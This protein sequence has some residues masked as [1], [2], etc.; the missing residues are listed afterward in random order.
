[1]TPTPLHRAGGNLPADVT[2]F[3]GRRREITEVKR[4]L[5]TARL[6]TLTGMGG[7][8]KTRLALRTAADLRRGF[9]HGVWVVE[10]AGLQ[11]GGL[12][13]E[14]VCSALRIHDRAAA[15][16]MGML[17]DFLAARQLL[18]ILDN[19]EHVI[20]ECA[21]LLDELLRSCPELRVLTT[22]R[23][24][25]GIAGEHTLVVPPLS[26]PESDQDLSPERLRMY[27]AVNL[28]VER[29]VA[30]RPGFAIDA[31]NKDAIARICRR[32]DGIPL[33]LELAAGRLRALSPQQLLERLDDR[34]RLLT[35]GS[36]TALPRQQTLRALIDWSYELCSSD[37]QV[38]WAR[39]STFAD[40]FDVDAAEEVCATEGLPVERVLD[41]VAGLVDK[42]VL[43]ADE[44]GGRVRYLLLETL[45]EYGLDRLEA[46]G[47][48]VSMRRR[49]LAWCHRF[50]IEAESEWAGPNQVEWFAR[51]Q[52]EHGNLR[53]ALNFCLDEPGESDRG[54]EMAS[55][56]R[57]Y[58]LTSGRLG[59]GRLWLDR[60]LATGSASNDARAKGMYVAGYLAIMLND[61]AAAEDRLAD[62]R[63]LAYEAGNASSCAYIDQISGLS[64]LF[65]GDS[66]SASAL[67]GSALA[68]HTLLGDQ[69]AIVYD[70]VGLAMASG[71]LG[72]GQRA[73]ELF[74]RC[75]AATES[76]GEHWLRALTLWALGI[77]AC[78]Q[79]DFR[80]A[81]DAQRKS[82]R[83]RLP[84]NDRW[85][86]GLNLDALAW[87]VAAEGD[88]DRAARLFGAAEAIP[89]TVG[90][91]LATLG[92][93]S[94]L[95]SAYLTAVRG[96][97]GDAAFE[98]AFQQ[99][100]A[101]SF[102]EAVAFALGEVVSPTRD[103]PAD[104]SAQRDDALT[105]RE[106]EIAELIARGLSNKEIASTLV[107]AQRTAE[108]H[109]GHILTKLGFTSRVQVA[110]W[111]AGN[112]V[113]PGERA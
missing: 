78:R 89:Q 29:A 49:Q 33:A 59:E 8:G 98:Q 24:S 100:L 88:N 41:T 40:G 62:A 57:Y 47:E 64:A 108:A 107:I 4:L 55:A 76:R 16:S 7:V 46:T 26:L 51:L 21:R 75:V 92:Q 52:L 72:D 30:L 60:L 86:I 95:H 5:P 11:D 32:L 73:T 36:R 67:F 48:I 63:S 54:L 25:L 3:I 56:L 69:T 85:D 12:V 18:L 35:G 22:S 20:E 66:A 42:S 113:A 71:L 90:T 28:L 93:L 84:F 37:E 44:R 94:G 50:A 61:F 2:S 87:A 53:A 111:V 82:I 27:D 101:F 45:H 58:W 38:L 23:Q 109:V 68:A 65:Q 97:L 99:G 83:L 74:G 81:A 10:L 34:Y 104:P 15:G 105:R 106:R 31:S 70:Q 19:C 1:M 110:T 80:R 39:L 9:A 43:V 17:K 102:E 77:E 6:V 79:G 13:T 96:A 14:T 91:S 112:H 103:I